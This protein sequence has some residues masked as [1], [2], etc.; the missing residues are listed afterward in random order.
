MLRHSR[1]FDGD[2]KAFGIR[3]SAGEKYRAGFCLRKIRR[4][5][6]ETT[7]LVIVVKHYEPW[8]LPSF[9]CLFDKGYLRLNIIKH[10]LCTG[11]LC[12]DSVKTSRGSICR[13]R[14][15]PEDCLKSPRHFCHSTVLES[16]LC[17]P[18]ATHAQQY[19]NFRTRCISCGIGK[20]CLDLL[21]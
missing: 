17:L 11:N 15:N 18:L 6:P 10:L 2:A 21:H 19:D 4:D 16:E 9:Q 3:V 8:T 5:V 14:V 1:H 7:G 13:R 20:V 12:S